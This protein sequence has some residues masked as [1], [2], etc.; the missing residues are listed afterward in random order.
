M[1]SGKEYLDFVLDRP[2]GFPEIT[3]RKMK[4]EYILYD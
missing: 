3:Y 1:A 4:G 2:E